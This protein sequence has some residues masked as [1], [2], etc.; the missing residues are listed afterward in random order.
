MSANTGMSA[1]C[2]SGSVHEGTP[3]G[4]VDTV[5]EVQAYIAEPESKSKAQT[6]IFI[7]DIFG[8]EFKNTRLL[9]DNYAKQGFYVYVPDILNGD[10]LPVSFLDNVEP[11]AKAHA[12]GI[13]DKVKNTAIMTATFG[14]WL[15]K[16][17]EATTR[18][19][20]ENF[21]KHVRTIPGTGKVGAIG[22]CYGGRYSILAAD[23]LADASYACHPSLLAV[24][25]DFEK[26]EKPLSLAVGD[27]DSLLD[28]KS[29]EQIKDYLLKEKSSVP[30]EVVVYQDQIHGFALRSDWSSD[31][32]KKAMDDAE[33][34][35]VA[36]FKTHLA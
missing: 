8:Y 11:P 22:F 28:N 4:R 30:N 19:I 3:S 25:A 29:V 23:G 9:A 33:K 7:T 36:W 31:K 14:T 27:K 13:V 12:D 2:L 35:G 26:V 21:F 32:D 1:C 16:H 10:P 15:P 5:G 17:T 6:V 34:Q 24:P 18:P 20:V